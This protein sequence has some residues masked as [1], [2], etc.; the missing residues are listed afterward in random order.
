MWISLVVVALVG[1]ASTARPSRGP[2]VAVYEADAK[3]P[4]GQRA[5]PEGCRVIGT[6]GPIDQM[7]GERASGD[8]YQQQRRETSE[9]GGNVLLALSETVVNRPTTDCPSNDTS[10]DCLKSGQSWYRV[11]FEEYACSPEAVSQ[12]AALP[13]E[14]RRGGITILFGSPKKAPSAQALSPAPSA[15]APQAGAPLS[16]SELKTKVLAMMQEHVAPKVILAFVR[17]QTLTRK[18]TAEEIID[19][20]RSGIPDA[21]IQSAAS[22]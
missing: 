6:S 8:P 18:L 7:E 9:R 16:P 15:P 22:R 13:A 5:M 12:L 4:A 2:A 17:G 19:W 10:P 1:C 14:P 21:V 20:T 3:Q 11:R